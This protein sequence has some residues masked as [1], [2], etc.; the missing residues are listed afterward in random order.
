MECEPA[1]AV[2]GV[3]QSQQVRICDLSVRFMASGKVTTPY[4]L[5]NLAASCHFTHAG[6][7][8]LVNGFRPGKREQSVT[9]KLFHAVFLLVVLS[10]LAAARTCKT[11]AR[12]V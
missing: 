10:G 1:F 9:K 12:M 11:W 6:E 7:S 8:H 4:F 2:L 5:R 3:S